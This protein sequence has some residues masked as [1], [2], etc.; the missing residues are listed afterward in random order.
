M[1]LAFT[2]APA[3][4]VWN[5]A[6]LLFVVCPMILFA[7]MRYP[8]R[9]SR[10]WVFIISVACFLY[11]LG[12]TMQQLAYIVSIELRPQYALT[13]NVQ[14]NHTTGT[15]PAPMPWR[16]FTRCVLLTA[17]KQNF[18]DMISISPFSPIIILRC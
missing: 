5:L 1:G 6:V 15:M 18:L 14:S 7:F 11:G 3:I 9:M 8:I 4:L 12:L 17:T 16:P 13:W 10:A 2:L